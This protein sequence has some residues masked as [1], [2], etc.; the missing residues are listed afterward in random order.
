MWD[1]KAQDEE[2]VE[3]YAA[4]VHQHAA[5]VAEAG[6]RNADLV[7]AAQGDRHERNKRQDVGARTRLEFSQGPAGVP[8]ISKRNVP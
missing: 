5:D 7:R 8:E 3:Q 6:I 2:T 1:A 4:K